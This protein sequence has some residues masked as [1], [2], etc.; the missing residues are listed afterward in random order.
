[1]TVTVNYDGSTAIVTYVLDAGWA[2]DYSQVYA[3][4]DNLP[5]DPKGKPTTSPGQYTS[6]HYSEVGTSTDTHTITGL[7]GDIYVI[8]HA[9]VFE[10]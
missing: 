1:G 10:V 5:V 6:I 2:M 8:A 7:S 4:S 9:D 3:G